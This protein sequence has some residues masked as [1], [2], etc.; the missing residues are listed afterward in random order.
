MSSLTKK[1]FD[2]YKVI[3]FLMIF[4]PFFLVL[5]I[6][7]HL[8]NDTYWIIKTG[9]YIFN[10]GIPEKDFL[11]IHTN[12]DIVC[13]QWLSSVIFYKIFTWFGEI[14]VIM[15]SAI[16]YI[17][18]VALMYKLTYMISKNTFICA[19]IC[20]GASVEM[21]TY[22]V[23]RPQIFTYT[24]ILIELIC[25]ESYVK[26]S[27]WK[28]L[29]PLPILSVLEV[30][31]HASMWTMPFIIMLPYL[32]NALPIKIKGKKLSCCKIVPLI[33]AVISMIGA[34]FITPYG[35][36][37]MSF[38]FTT[39]IGNKVNSSIM[40]LAPITLEL[41]NGRMLA[42]IAAA[43][44]FYIYWLKKGTNNVPLR[45]H[46]LILG[47][48]AMGLRYIKLFAYF[49][50]AGLTVSSALVSDFKLKIT[51]K[52]KDKKF[53]HVVGGEIIFFIV[54]LLFV[55]IFVSEV[56]IFNNTDNKENSR[57]LSDI[58]L[59]DEAVDVLDNEDRDDM[60]LFNDFNTGGYLEFRGYKTYI[61]PRADSFVLEANHDFDYLT[62]SKKIQSG[63][64][65]YKDFIDKYDFTH[66]IIQ[67][68]LTPYLDTSLEHDDDYEKLFENE[69][70]VI[71]KTK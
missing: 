49:L 18:I 40:E 59:L 25:L 7:K 10:N 6:N 57:G 65:F 11:T 23:T 27:N 68:N 60:V 47:T 3:K 71:Y 2:T 19:L 38:I 15:L 8:D 14:G 41:S 54:L 67:K 53:N 30:N 35:V 22:T 29:I 39:S 9:E 52:F 56:D 70:Y 61:D 44:L 45:Y 16:M 20:I 42:L 13:Q 33:I 55:A 12:M 36:K 46:L 48:M 34:G 63:H 69:E 51:E 43:I 32:V 58:Q 64:I 62:E 28:Y 31:L 17:V 50:I 1:D 37:G 66:F 4:T 24:I 26:N 5:S 21:A